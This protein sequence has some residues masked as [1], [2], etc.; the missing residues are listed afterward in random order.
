MAQMAPPGQGQGQG[1]GQGAARGES[2]G[3]SWANANGNA[4]VH[5]NPHSVLG[6]APYA[7]QV[8]LILTRTLTQPSP[9]TFH[10]H[11][12]PNPNPNLNPN[13]NPTPGRYPSRLPQDDAARYGGA[14]QRAPHSLPS[15]LT[16]K[17]ATSYTY[18]GYIYCG[19]SHPG[20][21]PRHQPAPPARDLSQAFQQV[22]QRLQP[23]PLPLSPAR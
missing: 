2:A 1:Q 15:S 10:P 5:A 22:Q 19:C 3:V 17:P 11:T 21:P 13:P 9:I 23:R 16:L 14:L 20:G 18:C 7:P 12:N 8:A 6:K 4:N